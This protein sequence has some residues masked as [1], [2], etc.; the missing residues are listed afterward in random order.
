MTPQFE[1]DCTRCIF[2]G[3]WETYDLY[4]CPQGPF[5][6]VIAR[7]GNDGPQYASGLASAEH[8]PSLGEAKRRAT[9][10]GLLK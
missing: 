7:F 6:T 4:F 10:R 8:I 3:R 2:L 1:H 5:P 9:E